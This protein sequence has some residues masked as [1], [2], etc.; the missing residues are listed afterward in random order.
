MICRDALVLA[1]VNSG[2]SILS[3]FAVFSTLGF[4]A[5]QQVGIN[6]YNI[7]Y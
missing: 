4:M 2:A 1:G 7:W 6:R 5:K 3:G